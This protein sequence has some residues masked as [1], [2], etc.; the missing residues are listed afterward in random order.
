MEIFTKGDDRV[1]RSAALVSDSA[2][3]SLQVERLIAQAGNPMWRSFHDRFE[4]KAFL[5][6]AR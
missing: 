1:E 2:I 3:F 6:E 4:L 5:A